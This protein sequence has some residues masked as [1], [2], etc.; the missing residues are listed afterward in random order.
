MTIKRVLLPTVLLVLTSTAAA[1]QES[2]RLSD[3]LEVGWQ[4][5]IKA[6]QCAGGSIL[7]DGTYENGLRTPFASDARFVQRF[8]PAGYPAL[9]NQV[10]VC[11][12]TGLDPA[13]MGFSVVLYDD[14]GVNGQPGTLLSS[15]SSSVS[16]P[17][18][19]GRQTVDVACADLNITV[20]SGSI[21]LGAQWNAAGNSDFFVCT[22][23]SAS[24][25]QAAM[26]RTANGGVSWT[27]VPQDFPSTRALGVRAELPIANPNACIPD[28][29]TLCLNNGRFKVEAVYQTAQGTG[30][31]QVVKLTD[32]T[33]YLWFF[34][35]TNV[36]S[37]VKVLNACAVNNRYWVFAAG[38]TNQGVDITVTD[39]LH[40]TAVKHYVNPLNRTYVTI[41]DTEAFATCP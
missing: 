8:T 26:Y 4:F 6:A 19:F 3:L 11:W 37:V 38:L 20:G 36:E 14:N 34:S 1:A 30:T 22:D 33:G 27:S 40:P 7:D 17:T 39:T 16:I 18:A 2:E 31:S 41:T 12:A 5:E 10:C 25:P 23:E 21:Y 15:K 13:S 29:D 28:A 32:E 35:A 9:V 24:T